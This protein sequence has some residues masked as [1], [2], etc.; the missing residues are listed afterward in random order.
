MKNLNVQEFFDTATCTLTYVVYDS[1]TRDAVVIDPVWDYDFASS[2]LSFGSI[3]RVKDFL[4]LKKLHLHFI[5]ETHAHADHLSGSR[6]LQELFPGAKVGIGRGIQKVQNTFKK[7]FNLGPTFATDGSQFDFL[8]DEDQK[9]RAGSL[10][11]VT[12]FTPGHTPACVSYLVGDSLFAGDTLFI[13]DY[14]TGRCD[15]PEGSPDA[16]FESIQ[17][18]YRLQDDTQIF[19]GHD[20]Q[21]HG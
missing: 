3:H 19:V 17:K 6:G 2:E 16:L 12:F 20:Y 14:G 15:F 21:P 8:L 4:L 10:E 11:I 1:E 5:L 18:I 7:I 13:P 9:I